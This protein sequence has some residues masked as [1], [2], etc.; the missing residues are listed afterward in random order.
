MLAQIR[1]D[2]VPDRRLIAASVA[3][4]AR[5]NFTIRPLRVS[6]SESRACDAFCGELDV[7]DI[8]MRFGSWRFALDKLL[9]NPDPP[10]P[11]MAFAAIDRAGTIIGIV[12]LACL[13]GGDAEIALIVRSDLKRRGIGR[14]LTAHAIDWAGN[15]GLSLLIGYVDAENAAVLSL[16]RDMGFQSIWLDSFSIE[17]RRS[18]EWP[19]S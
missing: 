1:E 19:C 3:P 15:L 4:P 16:A 12:N 9:P 10:H 5:D 7:N 11:R 8:R 14:S 17:V 6:E 2:I 13:G 18:L